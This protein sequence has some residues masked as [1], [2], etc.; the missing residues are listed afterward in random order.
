MYFETFSY[1]SEWQWAYNQNTKFHL[2]N[3][4][5]V[6][7]LTNVEHTRM[8]FKFNNTVFF[9]ISLNSPTASFNVVDYVSF[10]WSFT[11]FASH[12]KLTQ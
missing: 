5:V 7:F 6:K 1:G 9:I 8:T 11:T 4:F 2:N 3:Y 12:H 10:C